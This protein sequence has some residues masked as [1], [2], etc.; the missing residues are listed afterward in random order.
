M[1][2][3]LEWL[4]PI[5]IAVIVAFVINN[6][7]LLN[8]TI[9]TGSM[10]PTFMISD[11]LFANRLSYTFSKPNRGDIVVFNG[12]D[13]DKL[14]V[15]RIIGLPGD[16]LTIKNGKVYIN[17]ELLNDYVDVVIAGNSGPYEVP[18]DQYFMMGDNR[19]N[20]KDSRYWTNTFVPLDNIEGKV[21]IKYLPKFEFY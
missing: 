9:P 3:V 6:F 16:V 15:K 18:E 1:K 2:K 21:F 14:L 17:D 5:I 10:E 4:K 11:R 20:S 8:I 19:N 13:E 7:I 12:T